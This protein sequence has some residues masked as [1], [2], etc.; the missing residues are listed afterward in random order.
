M[1]KSRIKGKQSNFSRCFL[2]IL[3][4]IS[5][6]FTCPEITL[7]ESNFYYYLHTG[8]FRIKKDAIKSV[9]QLENHGYKV[10]ATYKKLQTR[11]SGIWYSSAPFHPRQT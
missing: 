11:D 1:Q 3:I 9:E 5:V 2:S 4:V 6:I 7:S 10:V 8:S